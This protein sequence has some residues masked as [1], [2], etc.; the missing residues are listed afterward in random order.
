MCT[1]MTCRKYV[2]EIIIIYKTKN[3]L[4]RFV[5][6][7]CI[8]IHTFKNVLYLNVD[9][10]FTEREG[11]RIIFFF[12]LIYLIIAYL[13]EKNYLEEYNHIINVNVL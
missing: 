4:L 8:Y 2:L 12:F 6:R 13:V 5:F 10:K 9:K 3:L 7:N 11:E 1:T